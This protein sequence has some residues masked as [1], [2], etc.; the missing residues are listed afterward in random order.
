MAQTDAAARAAEIPGL[1]IRPYA[2]EAD[3]PE[4][5]RIQNAEW[6]ADSVRG[7]T[8]VAE[9]RAYLA[10]ASDGFDPARDVNVAELDGRPVAVTQRE[11]VD[12]TDGVRDYRVRGWVDPAYRRRGIGSVLL[13]DNERRVREVA[14]AQPT[15]RPRV[16]GLGTS[17]HNAG[18][19]ALAERFGYRPARWFF[20]MERP[21]DGELPAIPPMPSGLEVRPVGA[22]AARKIWDADHEAFRDHWGGHD[23]SDA[24]FRRW[25][26]STAT[27]S[28]AACSTPSTPR[29]TRRSASGAA[30]WTPSS[31]GARG[32]GVG[33]RGRSS[34][35]R[36]TCSGSAA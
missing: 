12:A 16:I 26:D 13:A 11:W 6:Q 17:E 5:V 22:D 31:P 19:V 25:L 9:E 30:G 14:A 8:S 32:G 36:S 33:W 15:D 3:L 18:A 34:C 23:D 24:N 28:P 21:I 20:D 1:V 7:R 35:A 29:R 2:G 10:H 4:I 27:R